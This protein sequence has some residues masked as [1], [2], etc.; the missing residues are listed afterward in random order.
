MMPHVDREH[1]T[2]FASCGCAE[3]RIAELEA[4]L[5]PWADRWD[6]W[7]KKGGV[8]VPIEDLD[9]VDIVVEDGG[10]PALDFYRAAAALKGGDA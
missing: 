4:A 7:E 1:T 3:A 6:E 9:L 10:F 8:G 2:H 5:R